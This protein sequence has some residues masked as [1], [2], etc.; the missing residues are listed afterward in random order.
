M[1]SDISLAVGDGARRMTYAELAATRGI[2]RASAKRLA[3][4]HRWGRQ[5]GNDGVVRVT[6]PLSALVHT[7]KT[8]DVAGDVA[9]SVI[10]VTPTISAK[11]KRKVVASDTDSLSSAT[12]ATAPVT[13]IDVTA[14]VAGDVTPTVTLATEP[15]A[16]AVEVL[17]AQLEH[18]RDRANRSEHRVDELQRRI[19]D[20]YTA[21]ADARAAE[22]I[23]SEAAVALR[24]QLDLLRVRRRWWRRWFEVS[25]KRPTDSREWAG[26]SRS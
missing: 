22:R 14:D 16:R 19:D 7:A 5:V 4:R 8:Q 6:V 2:S 11:T 25:V 10:P 26:T 20:L 9:P 1:A 21:L 13:A 12:G 17:G 3:Q 24:H 15:L 23:S 18:E